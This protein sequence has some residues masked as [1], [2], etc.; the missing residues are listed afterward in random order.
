MKKKHAYAIVFLDWLLAAP[1]GLAQVGEEV[2]IDRSNLTRESEAV[3][4]KTLRDIHSLHATWFRRCAFRNDSPKRCAKFV[5]E[6]KLAEENNL[7]FLANV[8]AAQA[9]Y[10]D[11]YQN[12][13]AGGDFRKRCGWPQGSSQL[14]KMNLAKLSQRL[15]VQF[16]A[17]KAAHLTIDA[18][19]MGN[20]V[21]WIC[22]NGGEP[23]GHVT[24]EQ[25]F[26][27]AVRGY[28]HFLKPA[29]EVILDP[30]YVPNATYHVDGYGTH[31]YPNPDD[32]DHSV[33]DLIRQDAAISRARQALLDL[34]WGLLFRQVSQQTGTDAQ[35]GHTK[36][37]CPSGQI[38][39][40][41]G[42]TFLLCL[43]SRR[44]SAHRCKW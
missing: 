23:D 20:E 25:E 38:A 35:R 43:L 32:L 28:A 24:T 33:T 2:D 39:H 19:G 16:D 14:S 4:E 9:D 37:L 12:P 7:Q 36:F 27:T 18:F 1:A 42:S 8:L 3:Q 17:V 41:L 44:Q 30:R 29:A 5:N 10:D 15:R 6:F 11:G 26:M 13:K 22:F 31:I 34:K 40:P 21:D